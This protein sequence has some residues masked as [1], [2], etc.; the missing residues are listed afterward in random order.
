MHSVTHKWHGIT[1]AVALCVV[2]KEEAGEGGLSV[3]KDRVNLSPRVELGLLI[4]AGTAS[5]KSWVRERLR[6]RHSEATEPPHANLPCPPRLCLSLSVSLLSL[7]SSCTAS[8]FFSVALLSCCV[9]G[10]G[11]NLCSLI[12][13]RHSDRDAVSPLSYVCRWLLLNNF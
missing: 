1:P 10:V 13:D 7:H 6:H 11:C 2:N 9:S 5:S 12:F 8:G 3:N 4:N